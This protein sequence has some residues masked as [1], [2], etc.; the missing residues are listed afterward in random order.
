MY[1]SICILY[2]STYYIYII[3]N[4]YIR[5]NIYLLIVYIYIY[6]YIILY[7]QG[8][9]LGHQQWQGMA[10]LH[11]SEIRSQLPH[12]YTLSHWSVHVCNRQPGQR[13]SEKL[14]LVWKKNVSCGHHFGGGFFGACVRHSVWYDII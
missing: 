5:N 14:C 9:S 12:V 7:T 3:S 6:I 2:K 8:C 13:T 11:C 1:I 4:F 10:A